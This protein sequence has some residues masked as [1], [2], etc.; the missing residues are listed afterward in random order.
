MSLN[1]FWLPPRCSL[2]ALQA[3]AS[4]TSHLKHSQHSRLRRTGQEKLP[5]CFDFL[6]LTETETAECYQ[7]IPESYS[8][9]NYFVCIFLIM[10]C[11]GIFLEVKSQ[12]LIS[13][14]KT[15]CRSPYLSARQLTKPVSRLFVV[16]FSI[17]YNP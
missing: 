9:F 3:E 11:G 7:S 10:L 1:Y 12:A 16:Q 2:Q 6:Q 17:Q 13:R 4:S 8:Q 5:S 14:L 15:A